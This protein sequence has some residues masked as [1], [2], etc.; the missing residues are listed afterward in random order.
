MDKRSKQIYDG[1]NESQKAR[2][3]EEYKRAYEFDPK[4]PLFGLSRE[5]LSGPRLNRRAFLRLLAASGVAIPLRPLIAAAGIVLPTAAAGVAAQSGGELTAG[6]AG[7]A[8]IA[9]LD[10]AQINQ[11]LEFQIASNVLSGLT[12]INADLDGGRRPCR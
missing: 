3:R 1:L 11:V 6:W 5:E 2:V 10:P 7:T 8:E 12:H 4:D 9:T